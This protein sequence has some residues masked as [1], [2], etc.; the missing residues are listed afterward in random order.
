MPTG[1][2]EG[3][4]AMSRACP[5]AFARRR[6]IVPRAR[7]FLIALAAVAVAS[8]GAVPARAQGLIRDAE[9][10]HI[11][12]GYSE[13]IFKAA[14]LDSKAV[15]IFLVQDRSFNAFVAGGQN[16]FINT[17]LIMSLDRPRQLIGVIAHETG[18]IAGGH[19]ARSSDAMAAATVPFI[20]GLLLGV[21]AAAA[22]A[23]DAGMAMIAGGQEMA[24]RS[25]LKYSRTQ[26]SA[27]DQAAVTYLNATQQSAR[28]LLE[29]FKRFEGQE[30]MSEK[31]QDPFIQ[32]HPL[33]L[34]RMGALQERVLASP[35]AN[36]EEPAE[37]KESFARMKAKLVGFLEPQHL[38]RRYYPTSDT[39]I[40][41]R[42]AR[43]IAAYRIPD[44]GIALAEIDAL[45]KLEPQNPYFYELKG[46]ILFE[47]GRAAEAVP[48]YREAVRYAPKEPL[49][50]TSLGQALIATDNA[51]L[52]KEALKTLED[53]LRMD[54][55]NPFGWHQLAIAYARDG[56]I[57]M[58][59]LASA[60][61]QYRSGDV[62]LARA[63]AARA[64]CALK[65]G[66]PAARRAQDIVTTVHANMRDRHG[67]RIATDGTAEP[68]PRCPG[69]G[70]D[71]AAGRG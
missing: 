62:M 69:G 36:T 15:K 2:S 70:G 64:V 1:A 46:Q 66:T 18:H 60:E 20:A 21:A 33:S 54:P 25:Y 40:A 41:A 38:V 8:T 10:E 43:A 63:S 67:R 34:E 44:L 42:Y 56:Q 45:I 28:G 68:Q 32:S 26:E 51:A 57:G 9:I 53:A 29:T 35:Y 61:R 13:P 22:G 58:A 37:Q 7:L 24:L 14:G 27:A 65:P 6:A 17:G 19:L 49:I 12:R 39:S 5:P 16:L 47:N 50:K 31:R 52:N 23:P 71:G 59:D 30:L 11:I 4:E 55:D 48:V 3:E